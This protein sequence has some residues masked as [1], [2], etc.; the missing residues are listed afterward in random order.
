MIKEW[1]DAIKFIEKIGHPVYYS[2]SDLDYLIQAADTALAEERNK[3]L[4]EAAK[5]VEDIDYYPP[6][7]LSLNRSK[8]LETI[9]AL[10][11]TEDE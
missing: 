7:H 8:V 3:A 1:K 9:R 4:E 6:N 2:Q 5:A 10:K 11:E